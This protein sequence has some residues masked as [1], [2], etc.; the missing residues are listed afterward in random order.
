LLASQAL[1]RDLLCGDNDLLSYIVNFYARYLFLFSAGQT[2]YLTLKQGPW[3]RTMTGGA[4]PPGSV[5][6]AARSSQCCAAFWIWLI[7]PYWKFPS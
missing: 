4:S 7:C 5:L 6:V 2:D 3:L 1:S